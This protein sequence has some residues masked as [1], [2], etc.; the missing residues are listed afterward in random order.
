MMPRTPGF[1]PMAARGPMPVPPSPFTGS[2]PSSPFAAG[3]A[4]PF[5]PRRLAFNRLPSTSSDLP[6]RDN[7]TDSTQHI[8]EQPK[9]PEPQAGP[10]PVVPMY[11]PPPPKKAAKT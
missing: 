8:I 2:S 1:P 3:A 5:G 7:S 9:V 11:F 4:S 6:L 10:A